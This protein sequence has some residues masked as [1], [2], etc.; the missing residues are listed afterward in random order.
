[1]LLITARDQLTERVEGLEL[2]ADDYVAK[3][4]EVTEVVAR[5]RA[6]IRR[7]KA[8]MSAEAVHGPLAVNLQGRTARLGGRPLELTAREWSVLEYMVMHPR[9]V[10]SKERLLQAISTWD[11]QITPNAIEVYVCRLRSKLEPGGVRL[12]T[13]RGLGYQLDTGE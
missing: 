11:A 6:L 9:E 5:C 3:P 8:A 10:V 2:G 13:I 7:S 4:F 12:R 1:M